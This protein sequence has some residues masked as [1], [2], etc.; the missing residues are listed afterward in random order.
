MSLSYK[1]VEHAQP[2]AILRSGLCGYRGEVRRYVAKRGGAMD[3][4]VYVGDADSTEAEVASNGDKVFPRDKE[5]PVKASKE[6][7]NLYRY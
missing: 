7:I 2:G 6:A 1:D 5:F 4:A 3:W